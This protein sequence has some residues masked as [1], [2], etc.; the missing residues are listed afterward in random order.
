MFK[1]RGQ[2]AVFKARV[3]EPQNF[4]PD[5][6]VEELVQ[7]LAGVLVHPSASGF[8]QRKKY[9]STTELNL[10]EPFI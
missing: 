4:E 3:F 5:F 8:L 7:G 10:P 9:F 2:V 6:S 1:A